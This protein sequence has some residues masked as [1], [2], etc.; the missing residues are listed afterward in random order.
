[1]DEWIVIRLTDLADRA[2]FTKLTGIAP[3]D[4]A[5]IAAFTRSRDKFALMEELQ[6]VGLEAFPV[7]TPARPCC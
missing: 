3:G 2:A 6:A 7:L 5:A 1:V 4:E